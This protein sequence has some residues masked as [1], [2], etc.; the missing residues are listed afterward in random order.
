VKLDLIRNEVIEIV[1]DSYFS[2]D[3]VTEYINHALNYCSGV[4]DIPEFKRVFNVTTVTD[5]AYVNLG[6]KINSFGGRV[7]RVKY[8]GEDLL[9]YPV[10]EKMLD[11]YY[12][13]SQTGEIECVCLEGRNLW[14]QKIPETAITL[15]VLCYVNPEPLSLSNTEITWMPEFLQREILVNGTS[16]FIFK[17]IEE[18]DSN[19][20][21]ARMYLGEFEKG[22]DKLRG[23]ISRNRQNST[24]SCWRY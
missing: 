15:L 16:F 21:M 18:E 10:L 3:A 19:Q 5:S 12:D 17:K 22:L 8:N 23:W 11:S 1:G 4:I 2:P 24:Y 9:I 13:L 14:Y 7:R 6:E 20:P